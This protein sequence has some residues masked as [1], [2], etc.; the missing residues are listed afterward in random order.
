MKINLTSVELKEIRKSN[1]LNV[2]QNGK[3]TEKQKISWEEFCI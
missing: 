2:L 3:F 1:L